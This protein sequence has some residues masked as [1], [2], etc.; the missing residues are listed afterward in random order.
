MSERGQSAAVNLVTVVIFAWGLAYGDF[1][2]VY[3][4]AIVLSK[5]YANSMMVF[6]NDRTPSGH[7]GRDNHT[8]VI[9]DSL[10]FA[11][12]AGPTDSAQELALEG[13]DEGAESN[14]SARTAVEVPVKQNSCPA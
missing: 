5:L 13:C 14:K 3:G 6:L 10:R 2:I 1:A 4:P 7:H 12:V 9:L 8:T 11:T